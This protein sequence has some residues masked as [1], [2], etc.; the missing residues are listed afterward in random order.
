MILQAC[1]DFKT[2]P[3]EADTFPPNAT[4]GFSSSK[5]KS[6]GENKN[7]D[8]AKL[9]VCTTLTLDNGNSIQETTLNG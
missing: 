3:Q 1:H 5:S 9:T 7:R 8:V 6:G 2:L 4:A